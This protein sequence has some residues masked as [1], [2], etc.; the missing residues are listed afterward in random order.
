M[1][2]ITIN[3]LLLI[4]NELDERESIKRVVVDSCGRI[5]PF[6]LI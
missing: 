4:K 3:H 5:P 2:D 6:F 1:I